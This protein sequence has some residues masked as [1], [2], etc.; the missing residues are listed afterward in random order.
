MRI[1]IITTI[2]RYPLT[3]SFIKHTF[4]NYVRGVNNTDTALVLIEH[5]L[6]GE[7]KKETGRYSAGSRWWAWP[8]E[9]HVLPRMLYVILPR[10]HGIDVPTCLE[11]TEQDRT[12]RSR[13]DGMSPPRL[14]DKKL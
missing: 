9:P 7:T 2:E 8:L 11:G 12:E 5:G 13:S 6:R 1:M 3:C 10:E 4:I 14:G